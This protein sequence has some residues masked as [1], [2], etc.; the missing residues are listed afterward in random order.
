MATVGAFAQVYVAAQAQFGL[1]LTEPAQGPRLARMVATLNARLTA[2]L[3]APLTGGVIPIGAINP[4][5]WQALAG[6]AS[7]IASIEAALQ[8]GLFHNL[9][10]AGYLPQPQYRSLL[11]GLRPL[12]PVIAISQ[13]VRI[14]LNAQFS[15]QIAAMIRAMLGVALPALAPGLPLAMAQLTASLSALASLQATL[16][17]PPLQLGLAGVKA[18][19]V[20][21]LA[22]LLPMVSAQLRVSLA[23]LNPAAARLSLANIAAAELLALL[24][25]LPYCP[26][27]A[28]TADVVRIAATIDARAMASMTWKVPPLNAVPVLQVGLPVIGFMA[29]LQAALNIS[30]AVVPCAVCDAAALAR[31]AAA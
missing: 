27:Q 24:P 22:A 6:L 9:G 26:T 8:L 5:P 4:A 11:A 18:M 12:L 21:R 1:D 2:A 29:Q 10:A 16:G 7:A 19:L 20:S 14:P 13:Q 3:S 28:V 23:L 31:A 25:K 17:V 30:A 15:A